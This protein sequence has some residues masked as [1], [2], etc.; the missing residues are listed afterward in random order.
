MRALLT[1]V[2]LVAAGAHSWAQVPAGG[3]FQV[4]TY[5]TER[6]IGPWPAIDADG[7]FVIVWDGRQQGGTG[8]GGFGQRYAADGVPIGTEFRANAAGAVDRTR[9]VFG[10]HGSFLLTWARSVAPDPF[11]VYA[12][13]F[14]ADGT[15]AGPE[16][17]VNLVTADYQYRPA[18]T[19]LSNGD[20]VV[21]WNNFANPD[22]TIVARRIDRGGAPVGAEFQVSQ[23]PG[24]THFPTVASWPG[25]FVVVW[26]QEVASGTDIVGRRFNVAG[27][28]L[29][30][31]FRANSGDGNLHY[32]SV[33]MADSGAY[34]V[35]WQDPDADGSFYGVEGRLFTAE[36]TPVG[37]EFVVNVFSIGQQVFPKVASDAQGNFVVTWNLLAN[38]SEIFAR[39]FDASGA[40]RG[41]EF[42]VN[43][44]T[45][46]NQVGSVVAA[47]DVGNFVISWY[48]QGQDGSFYGAFAQRFGGLRPTAVDVDTAS[49]PPSDGNRVLEPGETVDVRPSWRNRNGAAQTFGGVLTSLTGPAGPTYTITDG[50]A[51]YG[52]VANGDTSACADCYRVGVSAPAAR[53][54]TH[55]D[56]TA[57]ESITPDAQGQRKGWKLHVGESFTDVPRANPYYRFVE[58]LL[59]RGVTAGCAAGSTYCPQSS[60]L[61][62]QMPVFVL[63]AREGPGYSP[64]AC[65]T[66]VFGDVPA[67]SPFC[68]WIEELARRGVVSGCGGGNYCPST[69]V[70]R[71]QMSVFIL[72][73]LDPSLTPPDCT[74][75]VFADVPA[76]SPFCR[77]IE[78]LARRGVVGGCGGGN[79][80]PTQPVTRE[81]MGVF[82]GL[83]FGL[84][85]YGP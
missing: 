53:P 21:A 25:G 56:A 34:V 57:V 62:E 16:F 17:R 66:P 15:P 81:Q 36:G 5:T 11:D 54:V 4:N 67:A 22:G 14:L 32:P 68:R 7:N 76:D 18:A 48:S 26:R 83:G 70:S 41:D 24:Q 64:V 46:N 13:L 82:I 1:A 52:T 59:H 42:R 28:A 55:W 71:E 84:Q 31:Q 44:Y 6:Q 29:G 30:A 8:P 33:A 23:L 40:P 12:R 72:R 50:S 38:N 74:T 3:E 51:A 39:R 75:P 43:S 78:E 77:W 49:S 58:T 80:C 61:R 79:Y 35:T 85:L 37:N 9:A 63:A 60:T 10:S 20:F 73:T 65:T 2:V 27:Q 47:D 19:S 69:P 45:T